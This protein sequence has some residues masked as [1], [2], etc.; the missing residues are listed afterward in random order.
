[1][2]ESV[3]R[4]VRVL[5]AEPFEQNFAAI[6]LARALR[7]FE[8]EEIGRRA[9]KDAAAADLDA[10]GHVEAVVM[11]PRWEVFPLSPHCDFVRPAV[12]VGILQNLD[13]VARP[14]PLRR[15]FGILE[16]LDHPKPAAL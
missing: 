14:F 13:P 7:V 10:A 3:Q 12:V 6:T 5:A 2:L 9:E 11:I 15:A 1:P 8:E 4:L 16:A